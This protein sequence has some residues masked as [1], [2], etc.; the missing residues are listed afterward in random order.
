MLHLL[1]CDTGQQLPPSAEARDTDNYFNLDP[2]VVRQWV[3]RSTR[4]PAPGYD[5]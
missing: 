2:H 4:C 5:C 1:C 3:N